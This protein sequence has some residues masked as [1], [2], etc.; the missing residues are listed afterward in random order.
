MKRHMNPTYLLLL[1]L[2]ATQGCSSTEDLAK[3]KPGKK[4]MVKVTGVDNRNGKI[5]VRGEVINKSRKTVWGPGVYSSPAG[6]VARVSWNYASIR[7]KKGQSWQDAEPLRYGD[8]ALPS[9]KMKPG[10]VI[11]FEYQTE[12]PFPKK[13]EAFLISIPQTAVFEAGGESPFSVPSHS[14]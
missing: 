8:G 6:G 14:P 10:E 12:A 1:L 4:I 2:V 9:R 7:V 3:I 13:R 5:L 11:L